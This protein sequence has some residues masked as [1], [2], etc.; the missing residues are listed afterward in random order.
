MS[1]HFLATL[2]PDTAAEL[3]AYL[4]RQTAVEHLRAQPQP[5]FPWPEAYNPMLTY[6]VAHAIEVADSDGREA[7]L[8]WLAV[9]AW[10]EGAIEAESGLRSVGA[11]S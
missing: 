7:A 8:V 3:T 5:N 6:L 9:H 10:F 1:R 11:E 2:S 4:D